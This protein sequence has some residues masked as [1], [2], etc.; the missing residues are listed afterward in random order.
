MEIELVTGPEIE[1]VIPRGLCHTEAGGREG[2][3]GDGSLGSG[4]N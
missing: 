3:E 2:A 1:A 4:L